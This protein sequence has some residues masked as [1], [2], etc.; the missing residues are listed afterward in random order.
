MSCHILLVDDDPVLLDA[1]SQ[2][3]KLRMEAVV[4]TCGSSFDALQ[5]VSTQN[6]DAVISDITMP[7]MDGMTLVT[8]IHEIRPKTPT[9]LISGNPDRDTAKKAVDSGAYVFIEKPIDRERFIASV[10]RAV[11]THRPA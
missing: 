2:T 4:D 6:Y 9:I 8:K 7:H 3:L 11:E 1:L 5:R 10:K